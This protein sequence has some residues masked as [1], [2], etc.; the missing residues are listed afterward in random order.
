MKPNPRPQNTTR[1]RRSWLNFLWF[2]ALASNVWRTKTT[3]GTG[4]TLSTIENCR[5]LS[6]FWNRNDARC[7]VG[8]RFAIVSAEY[9]LFIRAQELV[10]HSRPFL[11]LHRGEVLPTM[12]RC[13]SRR[14]PR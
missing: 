6:T 4:T 11:R 9:H 10:R 3:R 13:E 7:G 1:A 2:K 8:P 12:A 5:G 14:V